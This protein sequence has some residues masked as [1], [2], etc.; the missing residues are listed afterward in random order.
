MRKL[1]A[2]AIATLSPLA[3][4]ACD[5]TVTSL[6]RSAAGPALAASQ[7]AASCVDVKGTGTGSGSVIPDVRGEVTLEG[8]L[9]GDV[10][11]DLTIVR[12]AD[13]RSP[14]GN[15][16]TFAFYKD[17]ELVTEQLGTFTGT[18]E[19]NFNIGLGKEGIRSDRAVV[20]VHLDG[21]GDRHGSMTFRG[22]FDFSDF[23]PVIGLDFRYNGRL[24]TGGS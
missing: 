16:A 18:A 17:V 1:L 15:G 20:R 9:E 22:P 8:T 5:G 4:G 13:A 11:A 14:R 19:G 3:Y 21:P 6:D 10:S 12:D 23:P 24:C 2:L 7:A